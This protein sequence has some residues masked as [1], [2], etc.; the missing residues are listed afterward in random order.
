[1]KKCRE[2]CAFSQDV[3]CA[4]TVEKALFYMISLRSCHRTR[5]FLSIILTI[6]LGVIL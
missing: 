4:Q 5:T 1:M 6:V 2:S 3:I